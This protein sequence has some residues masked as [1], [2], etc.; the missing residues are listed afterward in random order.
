MLASRL[1]QTILATTLPALVLIL[2]CAD[3]LAAPPPCPPE[4]NG[5]L[6]DVEVTDPENQRS[7]GLYATHRLGFRFEMGDGSEDAAGASYNP[8]GETV[9]LAPGPGVLG[10]ASFVGRPGA[11][12]V[13]VE[14][15]VRREGPLIVPAPF[16]TA[17]QQVQL[18]LRKPRPTRFQVL[19]NTIDRTGAEP[20]LVV[21]IA[22]EPNEDLRP[23]GLSIR[24]AGGKRRDLFTL[25]LADVS[26]GHDEGLRRYRHSAK[27]A[28]MTISSAPTNASTQ[29]RGLLS[30]ALAVPRL[31]DG[32][33]LRRRF[34]LELGRNGKTLLRVRATI[35]CHAFG[36][37]EAVQYC[38]LPLLRVSHRG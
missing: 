10:P 8:D 18:Q 6:A 23:L 26:G 35:A 22:G 17:S 36:T 9:R 4:H 27:V 1:L 16:C 25:P 2:F 19:P 30:V 20:R 32:Q 15:I 11:Q 21:N 13:A 5:R 31:R 12:S 34:S 29:T 28:G 7:P 37:L 3:A 38:S 14:W 33:R 24:V